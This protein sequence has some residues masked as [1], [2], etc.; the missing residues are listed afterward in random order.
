MLIE[1]CEREDNCV[2]WR[3]RKSTVEETRRRFVVMNMD[4][5]SSQMQNIQGM[6]S[7]L[8]DKKCKVV[9]PLPS[10]W[11]SGGRNARPGDAPPRRLPGTKKS[12]FHGLPAL[13]LSVKASPFQNDFVVLAVEMWLQHNAVALCQ[14]MMCLDAEEGYASCSR[15]EILWAENRSNT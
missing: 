4:T 3:E 9:W 8:Y 1:M 11:L 5:Q 7:V 12:F 10:T 2:L 15:N 6:V 14:N 13:K